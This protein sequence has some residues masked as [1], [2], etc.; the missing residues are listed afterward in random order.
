MPLRITQVEV[1]IKRA[2]LEERKR[3]R[4]QDADSTGPQ[5]AAGH[6]EGTAEGRNEEKVSVDKAIAI[7]QDPAV[8]LSSEQSLEKHRMLR[9]VAVGC[10][11]PGTHDAGLQLARAAGEVRCAYP[12]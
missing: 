10:L 9:A 4:K 6:L 8:S 2:P 12:Q 5:D 7:K 3:K 11:T 1:A